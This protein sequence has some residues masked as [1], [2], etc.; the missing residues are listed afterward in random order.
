MSTKHQLTGQ[1]AQGTTKNRTTTTNKV[2][3]ANKTK[4][5]KY[6]DH[7][8]ASPIEN[9]ESDGD[10]SVEGPP[11]NTQNLVGFGDWNLFDPDNFLDEDDAT[12]I[13]SVKARN[14]S[15][16][17]RTTNPH[18]QQTIVHDLQQ[19][20][21]R[22]GSIYD[23]VHEEAQEAMDAVDSVGIYEAEEGEAGQQQSGYLDLNFVNGV[24]GFSP[25]QSWAMTPHRHESMAYRLE[26]PH[27]P[28][29]QQ[30]P[31]VYFDDDF[32]LDGSQ[33]FVF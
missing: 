33:L 31:R 29:I 25:L 13:S 14:G 6:E 27:N 2:S 26:Q 7:G 5:P 8:E 17:R 16:Y 10:G 1:T 32:E 12:D 3:K 18:A 28:V 15:A 23:P 9:V 20:A 22:S 4:D 21:S 30:S 11:A 19:L 24:T